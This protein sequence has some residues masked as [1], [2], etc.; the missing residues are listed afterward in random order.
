MDS[1][2]ATFLAF[3]FSKTADAEER[4]R[5]IARLCTQ[6]IPAVFATPPE[7]WF[8]L[9]RRVGWIA[10]DR[11]DSSLSVGSKAH[12][13]GAGD[14]VFDGYVTID[15]GGT[16]S[17]AARIASSIALVN[18][19][20]RLDESTGGVAAFAFLPRR[21]PLVFCWST[22]P[23]TLGIYWAQ[24]NGFLVAG[25]R[26]ILVHLAAAERPYATLDPSFIAT[27][28]AAGSGIDGS[29]SFAGVRRV[30]LGRTLRLGP[31]GAQEVGH[32]LDAPEAQPRGTLQGDLGDVDN[33]SDQLAEAL[34]GALAPLRG[35][36]ATVLMSGGKDSR[37]ITAAAVAAGLDVAGVTNG[38]ERGEPLVAQ[39]M[40]EAVGVP[41]RMNRQLA[42]ADPIVAACESHMRTEGL[43]RPDPHQIRFAAQEPQA[44]PLLHGQGHMLRGGYATD[45]GAGLDKI[46]HEASRPFLTN[47]VRGKHQTHVKEYLWDWI[48]SRLEPDPQALP[49]WANHDL[50]SGVHFAPGLLDFDGTVP[51]VYPL[52]DERVVQVAHAIP[53]RHRISEAVVF[54]AIRKLAPPLA[55]LPLYGE[56][57]RFEIEG[58][59]EGFPG[60]D[61]RV[62][63]ENKAHDTTRGALAYIGD[64]KRFRDFERFVA[65]TILSSRTYGTIAPMLTPQASRVISSCAS[66]GQLPPEVA[67]QSQPRRR[68]ALTLLRHVF[69]LCTLYD[70]NW[71]QPLRPADAAPPVAAGEA[72]PTA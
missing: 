25:P 54:S 63:T 26:P 50:R 67:A 41:F 8:D 42:L 49:Y 61:K 65:D 10:W 19:R 24:G 12:G 29:T 22:Q 53:L 58:E 17:R 60:R 16:G 14:I 72:S 3:S 57:W 23:P 27:R 30:A 48:F 32:P 47:W 56:M 46:I 18:N 6:F 2:V 39:Q 13:R 5:A 51:M 55:N 70:C 64:V 71:L 44:T 35:T 1:I 31:D 52:L 37:T 43:I 38:V 34:V 11:R 68:S 59:V 7:I 69:A 21:E 66:T 28:L 40:A 20:P 36:G 33:L 45:A 9:E 62:T 15:D 4:L